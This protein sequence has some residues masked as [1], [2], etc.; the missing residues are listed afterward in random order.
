[1][2]SELVVQEVLD[3]DKRALVSF[4]VGWLAFRAD[5]GGFTMVF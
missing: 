4:W 1:M 5:E 2:G 3:R